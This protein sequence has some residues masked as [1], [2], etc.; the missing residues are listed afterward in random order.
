MLLGNLLILILI[1]CFNEEKNVW[2]IISVVLV[3]CYV[4]FEVIVINDGF[5]DNIVQVFQQLV[6]EE[7]RLWVIYL[8]VN[9]GK[10]VVFKV[11]VVVVCG[12]LLVCIDGDVLLDWDIVVWLVV[13]LIYYLYVGVVIGNLWICI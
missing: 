1:F 12:D 8:V 3:Q 6:Q 9:Q 7:L 13:L 10:V 2:E 4:N 5:L 11:G